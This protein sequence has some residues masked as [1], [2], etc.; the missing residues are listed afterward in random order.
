MVAEVTL[1]NLADI[2][3]DV[4]TVGNAVGGEVVRDRWNQRAIVIATNHPADNPGADPD[5]DRAY[6]VSHSLH[7]IW[8]LGNAKLGNATVLEDVTGVDIVIPQT[9]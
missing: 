7:N 1:A 5:T 6:F 2:G 4:N 9:P 3:H 8:R